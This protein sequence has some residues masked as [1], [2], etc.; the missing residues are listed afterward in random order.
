MDRMRD[1]SIPQMTNV[2]NCYEAFQC[3]DPENIDFLVALRNSLSSRETRRPCKHFQSGHCQ[4]GD[5]CNYAHV[6]ESNWKKPMV[7]ETRRQ[8]ETA[9]GYNSGQGYSMN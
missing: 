3:T 7:M 9:T 1:F 8:Q 4:H 5:R 6:L 2:R